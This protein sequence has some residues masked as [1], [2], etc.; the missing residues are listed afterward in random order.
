MQGDTME[1]D[2]MGRHGLP[3]GGWFRAWHIV[4]MKPQEATTVGVCVV[5]GDYDIWITVSWQ[6]ISFMNFKIQEKWWNT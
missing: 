2:E 5:R 4:Q 6:Y 3:W 1:A